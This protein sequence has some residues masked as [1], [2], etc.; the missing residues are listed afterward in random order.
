MIMYRWYMMQWCL[1][2]FVSVV[3]IR[4]ML[5]YMVLTTVLFEVGDIACRFLW[6]QVLLSKIR[7]KKVFFSFLQKRDA[8]Y[9]QPPRILPIPPQNCVQCRL[10]EGR[11]LANIWIQSL[12]STFESLA[13]GCV[14]HGHV[15]AQYVLSCFSAAGS[16]VI[17]GELSSCRSRWSGE[18]GSGGRM[19]DLPLFQLLAPATD[20]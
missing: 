8:L 10:R 3:K 15:S 13:D 12:C 20:H 11:D 1:K 17:V 2:I 14:S 16:G 4:T 5:L 6:Q 18:C 19:F 7:F 9:S